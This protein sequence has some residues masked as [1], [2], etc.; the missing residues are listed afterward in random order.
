M[1]KE[2]PKGCG[3]VVHYGDNEVMFSVVGGCDSLYG[4]FEKTF[5][6][7]I[8]DRKTRD[9]I[10]DRFYSKSNYGVIGWM[11]DDELVELSC[12]VLKNGFQF[13]L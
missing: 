4:D 3:K 1:A 8:L 9:F 2:H 13:D 6:V 10:T 5:E 7:A 11:T 12:K